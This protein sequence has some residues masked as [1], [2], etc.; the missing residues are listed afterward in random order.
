MDL[1]GS[2]AEVRDLRTALGVA[3]PRAERLDPRGLVLCLRFWA[4][5]VL[6]K[7]DS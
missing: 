3:L 2:I 4:T 1:L 6:V 7:V 5:Q